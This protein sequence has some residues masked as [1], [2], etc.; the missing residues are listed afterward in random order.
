MPPETE[1]IL[2]QAPSSGRPGSMI[3]NRASPAL[4]DF[5]NALTTM[6]KMGNSTI[7]H[8]QAPVSANTIPITAATTTMMGV[9][10]GAEPPVLHEQSHRGQTWTFPSEPTP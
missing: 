5:F 8:G 10:K 9:G 2:A 3:A 7:A 6:A 4:L 1:A